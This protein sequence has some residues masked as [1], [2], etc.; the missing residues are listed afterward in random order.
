[1]TFRKIFSAFAILLFSFVPIFAD[2]ALREI[3]SLIEKREYNRALSLITEY[4]KANPKN[5][6]QAEKRVQEIFAARDEY[7][8][9]ADDFI[10]VLLDDPEND[11]KKLDM[12]ADLENTE[13]NPGRAEKEFVVEAKKAAQF[14]YFRSQYARI[15]READELCE[16]NDFAGALGVYSAGFLIYQKEFFDSIENEDK[17]TADTM[18][19]LLAEIGAA[20]ERF[21]AMQISLFSSYQAYI[22]ALEEGD[23]IKSESIFQTVNADFSRLAVLHTEILQTGKSFRE[24]YGAFLLSSPELTDAIYI[25]FAERLT[26]GSVGDDGIS[27]VIET[28]WNK[29]VG[30]MRASAYLA[31]LKNSD[32]MCE[33]GNEENASYE[34]IKAD[35]NQV[36]LFALLSERTNNLHEKMKKANG[37]S[38]LQ[39]NEKYSRSFSAMAK[40]AVRCEGLASV[41]RAFSDEDS[42]IEHLSS[43]ADAMKNERSGNREAVEKM[44]SSMDIFRSYRDKFASEAPYLQDLRAENG[45]LDW[46]DALSFHDSLMTDID[47]RYAVSTVHLWQKLSNYFAIASTDIAS[48]DAE[49]HKA[50]LSLLGEGEDEPHYSRESLVK[51]TAAQKQISEDIKTV[52]SEQTVLE[53]GADF[54]DAIAESRAILDENLSFL[55]S[56]LLECNQNIAVAKSN[57]E[58]AKKALDEG[59]KRY[60]Q[61]VNAAGRNDFETARNS[62][63]RSRAKF[64]ESLFFQED[65]ALRRR[66]DEILGALAAEIARAENALIVKEVRS[67]ITQARKEYYN[68]E[69]EAAEGLLVRAKDRWAITNIEENLEISSMLSLVNNALELKNGRE[70]NPA[71]PLYPEMSQILNIAKK[72]FDSGQ[73]QLKR[74]NRAK[75]LEYFGMAL[76]KLHELQ[77]VYP[78]NREASVLTLKI[79]QISDPDEFSKLFASKIDAAK[80]QI[81]NRDTRQQAYADLLDLYE[82]NPK[83]PGLQKLIFDVEIE[84]GIRPKPVDK[85]Q[86][87][88][89]ASLT[90]QARRMIDSAGGDEAKLRSALSVLNQAASINAESAETARLIDSVQTRVGG[91]AALVLSGEDEAKYQKAVQALQ[92]N[93]VITAKALV[94]QLLQKQSNRASAKIL[95]LQKRVNALL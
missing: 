87:A 34:E 60:Q 80:I 37:E 44:L 95:E 24:C 15:V 6:D 69:F 70:L 10:G 43:T 29:M 61:A 77:L 31:T 9:K 84:I 33:S 14:A 48:N 64:N 90:A 49:S 74:K 59:E 55:R 57:V 65:E 1:M 91:N 2:D 38:F 5:F 21:N 76:S 7:A 23:F 54:E 75:A 46:H 50:A 25:A 4:M 67:L 73:K 79:A 47:E 93:N 36:R 63:A 51:F 16:K 56:L 27:G 78:L 18:R 85:A 17:K 11:K 3:D 86:E 92:K 35:S 62:L 42:V 82:I 83:Y 19:K 72:Y 39:A 13:K 66:S 94:E 68:G 20:S 8:K 28:Q 22:Q 88:R 41:K 26:N 53:K 52:S 32:K 89:A 45:G 71:A 12:I 40:W 81:K 58:K 30:D